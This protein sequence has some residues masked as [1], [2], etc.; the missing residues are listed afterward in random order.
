MSPTPPTSTPWFDAHLDLAYLAVCGRDMRSADLARCGGPDL[1]AAVTLPSL[2]LGRVRSCLATVFTEMDGSN[3]ASY[4]AGDAEAA[5]RAGV[6]QMDV[7]ARWRREGLI[8]FPGDPVRASLEVRILIE[9]A[10]PVTDPAHLKGWAAHGVAAVGLAW[11]KG[12]R[13]AGGNTQAAGL[14]SAGRD[15]VLEIDRLGL[16]HDV[17]HLSDAALDDLLSLATGPVIASHSNC[18]ALIDAPGDSPTQ[19]HL[20]D[21]TIRAVAARGGVIGL[22]LYSAFLRRDGRARRA[23]VDD[24]IRHV[25]RVADVAGR[26]SAVG[27]GSDMDGGFGADRMPEGIDRPAHLPRLLDALASRGWPDADITGFAHGHW[28]A[29]WREADARQPD[30]VQWEANSTGIP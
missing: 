19:R 1:P 3:E 18:R 25:E 6:A 2:S 24:C 15:F 21:A 11:A 13:Y 22:N 27:L 5:R 30:R 10:D 14:T 7:Y 8:S 20:T 28:D 17:A 29:L 4:P 16:V 26:R 23:T 12:S 9:G